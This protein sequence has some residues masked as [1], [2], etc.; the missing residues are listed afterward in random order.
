MSTWSTNSKGS[1]NWYSKGS[2][3]LPGGDN[4]VIIPHWHIH[5]GHVNCLQ[6]TI[7]PSTPLVFAGLVVKAFVVYVNLHWNVIPF[8]C[9]LG[10]CIL[11]VSLV[12][13]TI[14]E[15]HEGRQAFPDRSVE[16]WWIFSCIGIIAP[17]LDLAHALK[18][19]IFNH[20]NQ[21]L[22]CWNCWNC[23][24]CG[25]FE[26][27]M[28][29]RKHQTHQTS[30]GW[31]LGTSI[32]NLSNDPS[33]HFQARFRFQLQ[34]LY[35]NPSFGMEHVIHQ[36]EDAI[37]VPVSA[38][39]GKVPSLGA[40]RET[41]QLVPNEPQVMLNHQEPHEVQLIL[42]SWS[43][44]LSGGKEGSYELEL[45]EHHDCLC[46]E[47]PELRL[48]HLLRNDFTDLCHDLFVEFV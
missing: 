41:R 24:P 12:L 29:E 8:W 37:L 31:H 42:K 2:N 7:S 39:L 5:P 38:L 34:Q 33:I 21:L 4:L 23:R 46:L 28:H 44:I 27:N 3:D 9:V 11:P 43:S 36:Y 10:V 35:S 26:Y 1:N 14:T 17:P 15:G 32:W 47:L 40:H 22:R 30:K 45:I 18:V 16:V 25:P 19:P 13:L 20:I 6:Q 48:V